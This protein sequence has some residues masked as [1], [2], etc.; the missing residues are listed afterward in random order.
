MTSKHV[1]ASLSAPS[2]RNG[3]V[4]PTTRKYMGS[5][6]VCSVRKARSLPHLPISCLLPQRCVL[7]DLGPQVQAKHTNGRRPTSL[8]LRDLAEQEYRTT[9]ASKTPV[10]KSGD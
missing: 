3:P 6:F 7:T 4:N 8:S 10:Q 1:F 5:K 9:V 2:L